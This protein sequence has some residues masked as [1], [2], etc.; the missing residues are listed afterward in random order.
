[1][2][3]FKSLIESK[4]IWGAFLAVAATLAQLAGYDIGD[5]NGLANEIV[6]IAGALFAIYGRIVAVKRIAK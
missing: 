6:T 5:T 1:M 2:Y 4:T 3:D